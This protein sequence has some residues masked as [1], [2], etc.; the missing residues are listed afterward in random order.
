MASPRIAVLGGGISGLVAAL[1]LSQALPEARIELFEA[2][3]QAGGKLRTV[4][5]GSHP[6]DVGAEAFVVRRPEALD[7]VTE[8]GLDALVRSPA[9]RSPA[10]F[11]GGRLQ[12]LP[13]NQ[14]FGIPGDAGELGELL[15]S[16]V[17][18]RIAAEPEN[19]APWQ[20]GQDVSVGELV[21]ARFG[22]SAVDRLVDPML[23]GVY[24]ASADA[25]GLRAVAPAVATQL[26]TQAAGGASRGAASLV[27]AV[28]AIRSTSVGGQVFAALDGGY[29]KLVDALLTR[30]AVSGDTALHLGTRIESITPDGEAA[31]LTTAG[32]GASAPQTFDGI[33]CALPFHSAA[34][35]LEGL[36]PAATEPLREIAYSSS[37]VVSVELAPGADVPDLSGVLVAAD[38]GRAAKAITLS[39]RKWGHL[40]R[41]EAGGGHSLRMSFGR[42]GDEAVLDLDD[43]AL[44]AQ[45]RTELAEIADIDARGAEFRVTRW[46]HGLPVPG[47]GHHLLVDAARRAL[48][49]QAVPVVLANSAVAG[50]GV[51]A[52]ISAAQTAAAELARKWQ[53]EG[54]G[55]P[56]L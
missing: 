18:Q 56:R 7:L 33:V 31:R 46:T 35:L 49:E 20:V 29:R 52:C 10:L 25:L 6:V 38:A 42:Q 45:T 47:T 19:P 34:P 51:P 16:D 36:S 1:R 4:D 28:R 14:V 40:D 12:P 22:R 8:L 55:T 27:E 24:A 26:D 39:S 3:D 23:G 54:H 43:D 2:S 9:G 15:D 13:R 53:D 21:A 11:S 32:P 5:L 48:A 44:I 30:I 41:T 37:A 17:I 50:V